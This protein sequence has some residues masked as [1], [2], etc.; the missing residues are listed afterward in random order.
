MRSE[1]SWNATAECDGG[2]SKGGEENTTQTVG[3]KFGEA[4]PEGAGGRFFEATCLA[5]AGMFFTPK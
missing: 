4:L 2:T 5:L 3:H 1:V